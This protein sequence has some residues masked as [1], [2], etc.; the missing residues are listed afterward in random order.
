MY[1][2]SFPAGLEVILDWKDYLDEEMSKAACTLSGLEAKQ[3]ELDVVVTDNRHAP[4]LVDDAAAIVL[5]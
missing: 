2:S 4:R 3:I 5:L 1:A